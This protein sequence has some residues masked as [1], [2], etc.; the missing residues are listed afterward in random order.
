MKE[1]AGDHSNPHLIYEWGT[2]LNIMVVVFFFYNKL[3]KQRGS[4]NLLPIT[5]ACLGWKNPHWKPQQ[6]AKREFPFCA[7]YIVGNGPLNFTLH[8]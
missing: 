7:L 3:S 2:C 1:T 8:M 4:L 5:S 6:A